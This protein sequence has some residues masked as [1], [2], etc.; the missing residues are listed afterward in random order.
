M[1][2]AFKAGR[3][4]FK[5]GDQVGEIALQHFCFAKVGQRRRE[6]EAPL[7]YNFH[8]Y[9]DHA[10]NKLRYSSRLY[11]IF[12]STILSQASAVF[13]MTLDSKTDIKV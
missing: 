5:S 7:D 2:I 10:D 13:C 9:S 3:G 12:D 6:G 4:V 1:K 11:R 8:N